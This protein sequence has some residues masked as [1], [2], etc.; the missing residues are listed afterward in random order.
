MRKSSVKVVPSKSIQTTSGVYESKDLAGTIKERIVSLL[1][2]KG[3]DSNK[4]TGTMT[5]LNQALRSITRKSVP[6]NWPKSPSVMRR[7]VDKVVYSLRRS[8]IKVNFTRT[9]DHMRT[10]LVEFVQR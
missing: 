4:W 3:G 2:K 10:R 7:V 1:G 8:G 9:P 6:E 5:E